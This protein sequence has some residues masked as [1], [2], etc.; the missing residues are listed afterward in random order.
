MVGFRSPDNTDFLQK[1]GGVYGKAN[2][3]RF[4]QFHFLAKHALREKATVAFRN[5]FKSSFDVEGNLVTGT[6]SGGVGAFPRMGW[7][8]NVEFSRGGTRAWR[9]RQKE[10]SRWPRLWVRG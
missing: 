4:F 3:T 6:G 10:Q 7:P 5:S 2:W 9:G 8:Q 1:T